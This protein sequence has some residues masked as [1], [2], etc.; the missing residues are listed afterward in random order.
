MLTATVANGTVKFCLAVY[1]LSHTYLN[2][3]WDNF[4]LIQ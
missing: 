1:V 3:Y 4:E 2:K